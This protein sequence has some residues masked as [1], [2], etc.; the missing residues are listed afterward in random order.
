MKMILAK[1]ILFIYLIKQVLKA[2]CHIFFEKIVFLFGQFCRDCLDS[3][4][5]S[6]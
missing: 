2:H 5:Y 3:L 6:A 4:S 1:L